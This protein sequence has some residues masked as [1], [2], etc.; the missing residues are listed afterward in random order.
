M[1]SQ[2]NC[3]NRAFLVNNKEGDIRYTKLTNQ[4]E[5][6]IEN[7]KVIYVLGKLQI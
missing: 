6:P 1:V 2:W 5:G 7:G 4:D 3:L